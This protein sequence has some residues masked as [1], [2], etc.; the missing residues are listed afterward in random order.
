[1][2]Y[3]SIKSKMVGGQQFRVERRLGGDDGGAE[4][5]AHSVVRVGAVGNGG[6]L[7]CGN[8]LCGG[9]SLCCNDSENGTSVGVGTGKGGVAVGCM[10][11]VFS[12]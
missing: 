8:F 6:S 9:D 2:A 1:M 11:P 4:M 7:C 10:T 5:E 12:L 3:R